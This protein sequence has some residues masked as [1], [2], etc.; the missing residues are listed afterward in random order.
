MDKSTQ[1]T[2]IKLSESQLQNVIND[3]IVKEH[4]LNDLFSLLIN[5]LMFSEQQNFL[6]EDNSEGIKVMVI[7]QQLNQE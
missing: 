1:E 5:G 2:G 6:S 4:G 3:H 7:D